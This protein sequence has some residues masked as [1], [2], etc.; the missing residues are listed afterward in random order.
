M[1]KEVTSKALNPI[2]NHST[3]AALAI[4]DTITKAGFVDYSVPATII[5]CNQMPDNKID[6]LKKINEDPTNVILYKKLADI[7]LNNFEI[8]AFKLNKEI[9][10]VLSK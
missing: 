7:H 2:I 8:T 9:I 5:K 6:L 3:D 4:I 1:I 10:E